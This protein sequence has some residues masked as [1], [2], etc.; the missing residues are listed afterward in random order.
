VSLIRIARL[1]ALVFLV[2]FGCRSAPPADRTGAKSDGQSGNTKELPE[3]E[4]TFPVTPSP[5]ERVPMRVSLSLSLVGWFLSVAA[6]GQIE[7]EPRKMFEPDADCVSAPQL[8]D[9]THYE[10][11]EE[12]TAGCREFGEGG[13]TECCSSWTSFD[14]K[15]TECNVLSAKGESLVINSP[16]DPA[17]PP[18]AKCSVEDEATLYRLAPSLACDCPTPSGLAALGFEPDVPCSRECFELRWAAYH[19][20]HK[21]CRE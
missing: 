9:V 13:C 16:C 20:S 10:S 11:A 14:G 19:C 6:C 17:C 2:G 1:L 7:K 4:T 3:Q 12:A 21:V 8:H 5:M 18:C 15:N